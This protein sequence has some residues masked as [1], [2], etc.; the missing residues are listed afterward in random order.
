MAGLFPSLAPELVWGL[1]ERGLGLVF[2]ISFASLSGQVVRSAGRGGGFP[3]GKRLVHIAED[4]PG[5]RRIFYFPT[6]LWLSSSD[7]M[8]RLLT[9]TGLAGA[10]AAIYG[11]PFSHYGI[12]SCYVSYLSLDMAIGLIFPWDCLL[13]E[14]A[15]LSLFL[16]ET[17]A[18]P[19]LSAV[20]APAPA[21]TWAFR[22]LL[23]R[24]MFGFGKQKFL[25]ST[26]KDL[27]YLKGFL[28]SQPLP[29]PFGWYAQKLP[30]ALLRPLVLFMFLVEIPIPFFALIPGPLSIIC[31]VTTVFLMIGIQAMGSFGYFSLLTIAGS[32][33]LLD[34]VTPAEL[35]LPE[36]FSAGAP[37]VVNTVVVV[38]TLASGITFLFNSW[39][40]QSWHLWAVWYRLPSYLSFPVH[41]L[42]V[43]HPFRWLHPYGV[44]P[45]NTQVSV[46]MSLLV[47]VTWDERNWEELEFTFSPSNDRSPPRFVAPHH[48]RGDQAVIYETFGLN[49]TSLISSTLGPY[50]P[51]AY[52]TAP[53][54]RVLCQLITEGRGTDY[55]KPTVLSK[56]AEPPLAARITTVMLEPISLKERSATGRW[57]KRTY[58]GPH[59]PPRRRDPDF[60]KYAWPEPELW[61]HDAIFWRRRSK[62]KRLMDRSLAGGEDPM[63]LALADSNLT[64]EE[65]ERF[66]NEFIPLA[67]EF[68]QNSFDTLPD[69]V[70]KVREHF[71][72]DQIHAL[73]RLLQRFSLLLVARLEPLYLGRMWKPLIP[74]KTYFHLW[75]AVQHV[76]A[77]G[78]D[79][80]LAALNDPMSIA[81]AL[82]EMT[83][84][85]G[86]YLL[87]I[88]RFEPMI[89]ESQKLRLLTAVGAP[90]D[91]EAKRKMAFGTEG[92]NKFEK[93]V[94]RM[95]ETFSGFFWIMP[96]VR[97]GFKGPRFD[98]GYPELYPSFQ[99]LDS[100]E[101]VV[102]SYAKPPPDVRI[103][104]AQSTPA[105]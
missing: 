64:A 15:F 88:F 98:Q 99:Q 45:P 10:C 60:W 42:R 104:I 17:L 9:F 89:F 11:G 95:S 39:L 44:F 78:K 4:F 43:L 90:H 96:Y 35:R 50:E 65:V 71:S 77:K 7:A 59:T 5:I 49:P 57:W 23:F 83:P 25:G 72:R 86:V 6:L 91:D 63:T 58:V 55:M 87:S 67:R 66:W 19:D 32:I 20:A 29:S 81:S 93:A 85:S 16:P 52:G 97:N 73:Y 26:S 12:V 30:V 18:L 69:A 76:I 94:V 21:L 38:H 75:L 92:M 68:D 84:Q 102:R 62:L 34:N 79:A 13:F 33:P 82:T 36:L 80:Y 74:A 48:P 101:V 3:I 46:K 70:P 103:P 40:A 47:E 24:V 53:A 54:A 56:H 22:L 41:M 37:I 2:L 27:A 31:A 100:G 28:V 61:H 8:L 14:S 1:Y 51:Y 105:E